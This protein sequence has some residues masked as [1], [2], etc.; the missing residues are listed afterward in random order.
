[1]SP[2]D[3]PSP[4][5]AGRYRGGTGAHPERHFGWHHDN[6]SFAIT[7]MIQR[8][9]GGAVFEY[10]R[11]VRDGDAAGALSRQCARPLDPTLRSTAR[12]A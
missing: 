11:D 7:L 4:Y 8:P 2:T 9:L 5:R 1:M 6:S 12:A 3:S 10:V